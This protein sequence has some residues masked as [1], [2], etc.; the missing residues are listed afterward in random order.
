MTSTPDGPRSRARNPLSFF[1]A[2]LAV[3]GGLLFVIVFLADLFGLHTNPYLGMLFF[4]VLPGIFI[5]GLLLIPLGIWRERRRARA[6]IAVEHRWFRL[7]LN[8]P[9]QRK[10]TFWVL[11]LTLVNVVIVSLAAY[12]GIEYMDSVKFCGQVCH[13]VMKPE[14]TAFQDSPHSRLACVTC[15][16]GPGAS[17]FAKSKISGA[18]QVLAVALHTYSRPIASPVRNLR[19]ARETCEQCHWP[20]KF[21]GDM[22]KTVHDY[23]DDEKNTDTAIELAVHVGGGSDRLGIATGIHWHM[24]VANEVTYIATD[25]KRQVIP[26][27]RVKDHAGNVREYSVDGVTADDLAKGEQRRMD[28]VDCHN[29]PSHAFAATAERAINNAMAMGEIPTTLPFVKREASAALK[30]TYATETAAT[31]AIASRLREFYRTKYPD[32]YMSRRQEVEKAVAGAQHQYKRN[33]FPDM[34]ITFGTYPNNIGHMDFPG[35]FRCHDGNHKAKDG[36]VIGQ[37]CDMCHKLQ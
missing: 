3:L 15:H 16:I 4:L 34:N 33:V 36:K 31:D 14:Y 22:I 28:C 13:T 20:E 25:D 1:G 5:F 17:W 37:D 35:C 21:H 7:D 23:G 27:V 6:G 24:N 12:S 30:G 11:A 32:V 8:D 9:R 18:R 26:W 29:R 19:P 10:V 2:V